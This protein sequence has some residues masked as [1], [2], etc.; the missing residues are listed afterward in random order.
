MGTCGV[1]AVKTD[2]GLE[3]SLMIEKEE[4]E[5]VSQQ[6]AGEKLLSCLGYVGIPQ[7]CWVMCGH[8]CSECQS[9]LREDSIQSTLYW[10]DG[11]QVFCKPVKYIQVQVVVQDP[12]MISR[13][14]G[15]FYLYLDVSPYLRNFLPGGEHLALFCVLCMQYTCSYIA[16]KC[17]TLSVLWLRLHSG[18][19]VYGIAGPCVCSSWCALLVLWLVSSAGGDIV[20]GQ[21]GVMKTNLGPARSMLCA[22]L[23]CQ[24]VTAAILV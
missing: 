21:A 19:T 16:S 5:M 7:S 6:Q 11:T 22:G 23:S 24:G 15:S 13:K 3:L 8:V 10:G 9:G 1:T 12:A 17:T 4:L 18:H 20:V 2:G 14:Q